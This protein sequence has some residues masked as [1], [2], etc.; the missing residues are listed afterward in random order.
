VNLITPEKRRAAAGLVREGVSVSLAGDL[1]VMQRRLNPRPV[2]HL[3]LAL[4]DWPLLAALGAAC[5]RYG[6]AMFLLT[7]VPPRSPDG[8]GSPVNPMATF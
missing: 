7:A 5:A 3:M 4:L 6:R 8:S 1:D 2:R